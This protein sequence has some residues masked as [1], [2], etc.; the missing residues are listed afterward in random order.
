MYLECNNF[1]KSSNRRLLRSQFQSIWIFAHNTIERFC[2]ICT[3]V[4]KGFKD[5]TKAK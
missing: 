4:A 2:M 3:D 1:D 5:L